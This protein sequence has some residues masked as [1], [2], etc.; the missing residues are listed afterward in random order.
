[1][2]VLGA[3]MPDLSFVLPHWLYWAGLIFFPLAAMALVGRQRRAGRRDLA[4]LPLAY[5]LWLTA[6]FVGIHRFYLRSLLGLVYLPPFIGILVANTRAAGARETRS[7]AESD[8]MIAE[9]DVERA[10]KA[11]AEGADGAAAQAE[12]ARAALESARNVFADSTAAF[13]QWTST[14]SWLA[15]AIAVLLIIDA[16]LLP[17]LTR[18]CQARERASPARAPEPEPIEQ[19]AGTGEDP[20]LDVST[21]LA[22][23]IERLSGW[24]GEFVAYWSVLAV[25][26][27]YYE[28][29]AR[30][31]FNSPT[32]WVHES[33]FLMFG[34]QYLISGAYAYM[35]DSHVR[36]DVFYARWSPR[37][38]ALVDILTS[39]FFFIFAGTLL[40]TGWT[41][42]MDAVGVWEV[43]FT[44]WAIQYWPVKATIALGAVLILL[45]GL[46]KLSKDVLIVTRGAA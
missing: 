11:V 27:Y 26:A 7:L 25:F 3:T 19:V 8:V 23:V 2:S 6:G 16:V 43:S 36:V 24:S 38:K 31:I 46:A 33:M 18:R 40:V 45:Q 22:A 34:M 14:A 5:M 42:L 21:R 35:S 9:F 4:T 39:L 15:L 13:A 32:N 37:G 44:E 29:V 28:V 30:Y 10:E 41:F 1:M 12:A 20:A 17:R